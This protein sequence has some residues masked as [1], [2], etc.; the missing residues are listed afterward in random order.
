MR[1]ALSLGCAVA[2]VVCAGCKRESDDRTSPERL[3]VEPLPEVTPARVFEQ[4]AC[5][6]CNLTTPG[7]C[8]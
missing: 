6:D 1:V 4:L 2:L 8:P 5:A 3:P 7:S